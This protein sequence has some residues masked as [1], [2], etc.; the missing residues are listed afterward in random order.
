[1]DDEPEPRTRDWLPRTAAL[2]IGTLALAAAFIAAYVGALHKPNPRDVPVA[3]VLGDQPA[4][5]VMAA[6]RARTDT[7]KPVEYDSQG[8]AVTGLNRRE[9]YA[10]LRSAP[11]GGLTLATASAGAP[12]AA[13]LVT[14]VFTG[15]TQQAGVPL[16]VTDEVPVSAGDPRG[17][18]PFYLAVG[19][20][21]GGYLASTALGV[22][23]GTSPRDLRGAGLRIATLAV[24]AV[25]LGIIGAVLVGPVLDVFEHNVPAVA[26]IGALAA[27][28]AGMV[29]AAVQ[30]WL[31]LL[32]TGLVILLLVVLG[33][34]GS[35]GIYAPE[36]LPAFLRGMHR[37]NVPGLATDLIKSVVYFDWRG[38]PWPLVGLLLWALAGLVGLLTATAFRAHRRAVRGRARPAPAGAP[39]TDG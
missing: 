7:I 35:G 12:A 13:E 1:M 8:A 20:V 21:L 17:L 14:Q 32:G 4:Q 10:V 37:W 19:L 22:S 38:G 26:V 6:V 11:G 18:V 3:V 28:A 24:H 39:R 30:G 5:A 15:A 16:Q 33:N 31:G 29:A 25:L 2:V 23:L 34:P 9:V 27:F 36:F